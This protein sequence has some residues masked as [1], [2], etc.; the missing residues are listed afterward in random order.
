[1]VSITF[2]QHRFGLSLVMIVALLS[3]CTSAPKVHVD[4]DSHVSFSNYRTFAWLEPKPADAG[5]AEVPVTL[6]SRRMRESVAAALQTK[7]Y[8]LDEVHPDVRVSYVLNVYERPKQSGMSI[9]LGAGSGSGNV[10]GGVGVSLPLG[11]RHETV[12]SMTVN[13]IDAT[14]KEQVWVGSSELILKGKDATDADVQTLTDT[15]LTK[16]PDTGK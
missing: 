1:M 6:A 8:T 3:A 2:L 7:G 4:Q 11:K 15:I 9:G 14:R 10:A 16:Y 13:V 5:G 12:A